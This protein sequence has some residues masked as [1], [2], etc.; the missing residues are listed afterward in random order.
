M[1]T[2]HVLRAPKD[3]KVKR[4]AAASPGEMVAEGLELVVF[5]ESE[6]E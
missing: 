2:E 3:G 4:L 5:E 6:D 1:Q